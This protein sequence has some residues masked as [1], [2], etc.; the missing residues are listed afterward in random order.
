MKASRGH[1]RLLASLSPFLNRQL[2]SYAIAAA[3]SGVGLL[4][5]TQPSEAKIVYTKAYQKIGL[6]G[7]YGLDLN[8]DGTKDVIIQEIGDST[9][10]GSNFL[11]AAPAYGNA[12]EGSKSMAAAVMKGA[13]IGPGQKFISLGQSSFGANMARAFERNPG[14]ATG[15]GST[16]SSGQWLNVTNRFL[17]V[18]FKIDG[19]T[20]YG[21][22]RLSVQVKFLQ[23]TAE[24]TGYAYE[25]V[26]GES[27]RAGEITDGADQ[28]AEVTVDDSS[29]AEPTSDDAG[30][31]GNLALGAG[32]VGRGRGL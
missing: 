26:A 3:A 16:G 19:K 10:S 6:N 22:A 4:A 1:N 7:I 28:P 29:G 14:R 17:G 30:S 5:L 23:I 13:V 25:T 24:L 32:A 31:L 8:N 2:N 27:I 18:K 9:G 15:G 21:W 11:A 12:I 20:H